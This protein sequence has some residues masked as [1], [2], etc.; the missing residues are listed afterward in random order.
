MQEISGEKNRQWNSQRWK[1]ARSGGCEWP[2]NAMHSTETKE[3]DP[4][5]LQWGRKLQLQLLGCMPAGCGWYM[6]F[7]LHRNLVSPGDHERSQISVCL[8]N[9]KSSP[10]HIVGGLPLVGTNTANNTCAPRGFVP[11]KLK[12][13]NPQWCPRVKVG[14]QL[15]FSEWAPGGS[16]HVYQE[17]D[18]CD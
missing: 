10:L 14:M 9:F 6:R 16:Y 7:E 8:W 1:E 18:L 15:S 5:R 17:R 2:G 3:Q 13:K 12:S 4:R 11:L